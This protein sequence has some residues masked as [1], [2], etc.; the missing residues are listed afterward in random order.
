MY[1]REMNYYEL[2]NDLKL[3]LFILFVTVNMIK[4]T[5]VNHV[6]VVLNFSYNVVSSTSQ[7]ILKF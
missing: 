7:V 5:H 6:V 2:A 3:F 1:L 4:I